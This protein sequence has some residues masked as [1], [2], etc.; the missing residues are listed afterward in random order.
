MV[1][2]KETIKRS[3]IAIIPEVLPLVVLG[4]AL[5]W[6]YQSFK[7]HECAWLVLFFGM[8]LIRLPYHLQT[9]LNNIAV[10]ENTRQE[11]ILLAAIF[12]FMGLVPVLYLTTK[13][14]AWDF[15][16]FANYNLHTWIA[17]FGTCL[18][19]PFL[20]LFWRSHA[21]LG[22]NWSPRLEMHDEHKL[23]TNGVYRYIRH[24]M[25]AAFWI[26]VIS[27]PLLIQ[28]WLAGGLIVVAFLSMYVLRIPK[29]EGMMI[30]KFGNEYVDYMHRT[31]RIFPKIRPMKS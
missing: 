18:I 17:V 20:I 31:G 28:N 26:A 19:V 23:V 5:A 9:K 2:P 6:N 1:K 13:G 15:L 14:R 16:A 22:R 21:D 25:Y 24:P 29:E 30:T 12:L 27:Q 11:R 8:A 7:W 3:Q 4:A 10:D